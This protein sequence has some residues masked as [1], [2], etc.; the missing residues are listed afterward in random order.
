MGLF[1]NIAF[2]K[3]NLA[4]AVVTLITVCTVIFNYIVATANGDALDE[5]NTEIEPYMEL[6]DELN[7]SAVNSKMLSMSWTY[8]PS[9]DADRRALKNLH[10]KEYP[11]LKAKLLAFVQ[12]KSFQESERDKIKNLLDRF[13]SLLAFQS[14]L[15]NK[16]PDFEAYQQPSILLD[17]QYVV[18]NE[19]LPLAN[20]LIEEIGNSA[21]K[22]RR[23][24]FELNI[25]M[26]ASLKLMLTVMPLLS[27]VI[28]L[29]MLIL[30][31]YV[32][33]TI[34]WPILQ[35]K[36]S[37]LELSE[38]KL[39][40]IVYRSFEGIIQEMLS[41]LQALNNSFRR[42]TEFA[43]QIKSGNFNVSYTPLSSEDKLGKALIEMRDSLKDY[44][45]EMEK[46]VAERTKELKAA[47][48][49][50]SNRNA[51][52]EQLFSQVQTKNEQL[53]ASE[54]ELRQNAEEM[55]AIN[56]QLSATLNNLKSTQS[57]LIQAEKMASLG[58]LIAGVAH[59]VNTPLGAIKASISTISE[60]LQETLRRLPELHKLISFEEEKIF[61]RLLEVAFESKINITSREERAYRKNLTAFLEERNISGAV[62]IASLFTDIGVYEGIDEFLPLIVHPQSEFILKTAYYI[63]QQKRNSDNIALAVQKATKVVFALKSYS[64]KEQKG[65]MT[66]ADLVENIENVLTLYHNQLKIGVEVIKH[67][68]ENL[69][70]IFCFPD[71]LSQVWTNLITNATQAM[72]NQGQLNISIKNR[73]EF[74]E[75]SF[76]DTGGGIPQDILGRI[77]EPFF[78]TKKAGEGTGLGLDIVRKIVEKHKGTI[79]VE[80]TEGVGSTF[81]VL[82]PT[83]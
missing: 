77:F 70:E 22:A 48:L 5:M 80:S 45:E 50:I 35:V 8:F 75:V 64:R 12:Q 38:G 37:L 41:A 40:K 34:T 76:T 72:K 53:Q 42:T 17:A 16:L 51:E 26:D 83:V 13:D 52:I 2:K 60:S 68:D 31:F 6:L 10:Q 36:N 18:E 58:Q 78:T 65:E 33:R 21:D 4:F 1:K 57:Q 32:H 14:E 55:V 20:E 79:S 62:S 59:E 74:L 81:T 82:L 28:A 7:L 43:I 44:A 73:N 3:L 49:E 67:Y 69:P 39:P 30:P 25:Q 54:E 15:M 9:M 46:K 29:I 63:A 23:N 61:M 24:A 66:K 56:E 19:V 11:E 47:N 27:L 71:E